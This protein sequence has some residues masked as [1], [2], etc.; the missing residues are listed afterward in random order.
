M[1]PAQAGPEEL[2]PDARAALE[3]IV[4]AVATDPRAPSS[5]R[6]RETAWRVHIADSLAGLEVPELRE[7]RA[8]ADVGAGAGFPGLPLAVVLSRARVDLIEATTRK[9][10]FMRRAIA[11]A[12]VP[13]ARVVCKRS[14]EWAASSPPEGGREAYQAVTAR[15]VGRLATLAELAAPLLVDGG[16]LV[17][18]KGRRDLA[19]EAE[20]ERVAGRL[21]V[22]PVEVR[23][24]GPYAG[25]RNRHL[26]VLRKRGATP[27]ELPRRAGMAK[28]RP[29]G[30]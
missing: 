21:A 24:V 27:A 15:A 2:S 9:C 12:G 7:A 26:H 11:E 14:E 13:D 19:E 28:K 22:E 20:L 23:W 6:D 18:W 1:S 17:V 25:S 30:T 3:L 5:V 16:V 8:I 4:E 10:E 29:L